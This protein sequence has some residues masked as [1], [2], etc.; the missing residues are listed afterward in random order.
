M[1]SGPLSWLRGV[2]WQFRFPLCVRIAV[3]LASDWLLCPLALEWIVNQAPSFDGWVCPESVGC[4]YQLVP[5]GI[6]STCRNQQLGNFIVADPEFSELAIAMLLILVFICCAAVVAD[7]S[8]TDCHFLP[9]KWS[10]HGGWWCCRLA[11][12]TIARNSTIRVL[13]RISD[14]CAEAFPKLLVSR[15]AGKSAEESSGFVI[16]LVAVSVVVFVL[17]SI[18]AIFLVC[19]F[20]RKQGIS[21]AS[22]VESGV[23][24]F[25][26][27]GGVSQFDR[28][29]CTTSARTSRCG[30]PAVGA[31]DGRRGALNGDAR[32]G[33]GGVT[34]YW[35]QRITRRC[36]PQRCGS[37]S[38]HS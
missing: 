27:R 37:I 23:V 2:S 9:T 22:S 19:R 26:A 7:N 21:R 17:F 33:C 10:S 29:T 4:Y 16:W 34:S 12:I 6:F 15:G 3:L 31:F 24:N 5:L 11:T 38:I 14:K 35:Q 32:L 36:Q 8:L 1:P 25:C 13:P 18:L 30:D 28:L 20:R